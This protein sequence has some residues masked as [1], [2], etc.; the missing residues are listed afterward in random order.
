MPIVTAA[1]VSEQ[2]QRWQRGEAS[3]A[4]LARW[5]REMRSKREPAD[6][7]VSAVLARMQVLGKSGVSAVDVEVMLKALRSNHA[8]QMLNEHF[9]PIAESGKPPPPPRDPSLRSTARYWRFHARAHRWFHKLA[10]AFAIAIGAVFA[11]WLYWRTSLD[12]E[13]DAAILLGIVIAIG[14]KNV[15]DHIS[16]VV[17]RPRCPFCKAK[18][19]MT[20][21]AQA[22]SLLRENRCPSCRARF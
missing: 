13:G 22:R 17:R 20:E 11:A 14:A 4:E 7:S 3:A 18:W 19:D 10:I 12:L 8:P 15:L 1:Q 2:L 5:S 16:K 6:A 21:D 9:G